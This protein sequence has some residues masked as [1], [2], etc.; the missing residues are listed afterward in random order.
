[1]KLALTI[2]LS[3]FLVSFVQGQKQKHRLEF[4]NILPSYTAF[5]QIKPLLLNNDEKSFFLSALHP[6]ASARLERFN[7]E[8]QKWE[9]GAWARYCASV[10]N[11]TKPIEVTAG[12]SFEPRVYWQ[13]SMNDWDKPTAFETASDQEHPLKGKYR[14]A[15]EYSEEAWILG[16]FP[17]IKYVVRSAEFSFEP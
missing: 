6:Q 1:M 11:V 5:D 14:L 8:T 9:G 13:Y 16:K 4:S 17:K 3:L 12:G 2:I 15:L 10:A 7:D